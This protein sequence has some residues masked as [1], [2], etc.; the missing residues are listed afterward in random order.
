VTDFFSIIAVLLA[1]GAAFLG[2]HALHEKTAGTIWQ[3]PKA[4]GKIIMQTFRQRAALVICAGAA[5]C[6]VDYIIFPGAYGGT[7]EASLH[8][9]HYAFLLGGLTIL[10]GVYHWIAGPPQDKI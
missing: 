1:F 9:S 5:L 7:Y 8:Q 2:F 4:M 3:D 10:V 6:L